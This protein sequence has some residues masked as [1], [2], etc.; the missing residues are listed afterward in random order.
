MAH[1]KHRRIKSGQ[2]R[3]TALVK[4]PEGGVA[5]PKTVEIAPEMAQQKLAEHKQNAPDMG[6]PG[7]N[8]GETA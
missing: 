5:Q 7:H 6:C 8:E 4:S 1:G 3:L 2:W